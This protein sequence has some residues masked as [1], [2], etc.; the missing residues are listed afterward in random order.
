MDRS[1]DTY[2]DALPVYNLPLSEIAYG[3]GLTTGLTQSGA[4][5]ALKAL[6]WF[7]VALAIWS[8]LFHPFYARLALQLISLANIFASL[9]C[10]AHLLCLSGME[11]QLFPQQ[12]LDDF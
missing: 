5:Y 12:L 6:T 9:L 1:R 2:F 4:S 7:K 10:S 11:P 8:Q 3:A